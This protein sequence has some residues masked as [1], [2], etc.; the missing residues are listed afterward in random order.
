MVAYPTGYS[1]TMVDIDELF[2]RH[3]QDK[4]HPEFARRLRAFL[5][6]NDGRIGI[7]GSWRATQPAKPGFAPEGRSFHQTQ[8]FAGGRKAFCAVDLVHVNGSSNHRSPTWNEVPKQGT[9]NVQYFGVHCNVDKEPWH[10]QPVELDGWQTWHNAGR[11]ELGV[12]TLNAV[13]EPKPVLVLAYPGTPLKMGSR[14][15]A[16]KLVQAVVG[17]KEDG[18]FA[19]VTDRLVRAWQQRNG[20]K[21]D[22]I[23][24]PVTWKKMFG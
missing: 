20:L 4:M 18:N 1:K 11:K 15:D 3:H 6:A 14:G 23:V 2:R 10:M 7:G 21:A 5:V 9:V 19:S 12:W 8:E 22:G 24:G 16:V 13:D 17:T